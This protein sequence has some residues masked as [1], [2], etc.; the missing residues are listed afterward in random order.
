MQRI[1]FSMYSPQIFPSIRDAESSIPPED[2]VP[3][4]GLYEEEGTAIR[5]FAESRFRSEG[6]R[7]IGF[8]RNKKEG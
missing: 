2:V 5:V 1:V 3:N 4:V 6:Q 7:E 8:R